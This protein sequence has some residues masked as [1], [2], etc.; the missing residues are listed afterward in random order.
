MI[1][2]KTTED[3]SGYEG[4]RG[5]LIA[6]L[7]DFQEKDGYISEEAVKRISQFLKISESK[8]Y[9]VASFYAQFRFTEPG[10]HSIKVC[11][12]TA[13]H[14]AGGHILS[15]A[16][17]RELDIKAGQTTTDGRFDYD[18]AACLG[19][20]ALAPVVKIGE[21]IHSGVSVNDLKKILDKYE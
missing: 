11:L 17:Q 4:K 19:C 2:K 7:Q 3:I 1:D 8:I 6:I 18:R 10:R 20:C 13:C 14:V 21:D 9:G 5:E 16:V 12:G 15:E